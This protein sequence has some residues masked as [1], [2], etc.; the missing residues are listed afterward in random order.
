MEVSVHLYFCDC[1][2]RTM[3]SSYKSF[4][5]FMGHCYTTKTN[6][7]QCCVRGEALTSWWHLACWLVN[8]SWTWWL[9]R[10][11]WSTANILSTPVC[12]SQIPHGLSWNWTQTS[13]MRRKSLMAWAMAWLVTLLFLKTFCNWCIIVITNIYCLS[14]FNMPSYCT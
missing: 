8:L 11:I 9:Q 5:K 2:F 13:M 4:T 12:P 6:P 10:E 14:L 7:S 1:T 3:I